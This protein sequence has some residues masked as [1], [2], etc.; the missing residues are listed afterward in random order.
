M[1]A[2]TIWT[3]QVHTGS[4]HAYQWWGVKAQGDYPVGWAM[5]PV[6]IET[7]SFNGL[8]Y[9]LRVIA[10]SIES[11]EAQSTGAIYEPPHH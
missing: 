2:P 11:I 1:T 9:A 6:T 4:E 7:K 3:F 8:P 10:D 5:S